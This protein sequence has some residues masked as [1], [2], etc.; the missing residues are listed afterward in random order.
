MK[1]RTSRLVILGP[2]LA[3]LVLGVAF[4]QQVTA[5]RTADRR[6]APPAPHRERTRSTRSTAAQVDEQTR[7]LRDRQLMD[8]R[9]TGLQSQQALLQARTALSRAQADALES[10]QRSGGIAEPTNVRPQHPLLTPKVMATVK[11][12]NLLLTPEDR[13]ATKFLLI[14]PE[15]HAR[16]DPR[17][18]SGVAK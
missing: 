14:G 1:G 5:V 9:I 13:A 8:A 7:L 4:G 15:Q 3:L 10:R 11:K 2:C 6:V 12:R 17:T 16:P 18:A